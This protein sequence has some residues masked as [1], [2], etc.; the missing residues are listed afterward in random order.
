MVMRAAPQRRGVRPTSTAA[1]AASS[2]SYKTAPAAKYDPITGKAI[3][4]G[5]AYA[6]VDGLAFESL[7]TQTMYY[8]LLEKGFE[9][10]WEGGKPKLRS[11]EPKVIWELRDPKHPE[12]RF[13]KMSK[14]KPVEKMFGDFRPGKYT[15]EVWIEGAA[16]KKKS[17]P[18]LK[19]TSS[20]SAS[21]EV[22]VATFTG[23]EVTART[24]DLS[25]S[26]PRQVV[27][28]EISEDITP[29]RCMLKFHGHTSFK[30]VY[31]G[32]KLTIIPPS[33][34]QVSYNAAI[35]KTKKLLQ[36]GEFVVVLKKGANGVGMTLGWDKQ[37]YGVV[38]K[39]VIPNGAAARTKLIR[40]GNLIRGVQGERVDGKSFKR[41]ISRLRN[42]PRTVV[43][44]LE[45]RPENYQPPPKALRTKRVS[46]DWGA[47]QRDSRRVSG[48][49]AV[50]RQRPKSIREHPELP[51][52]SR[53]VSGRVAV[54]H[55]RPTSIRE[56]SRPQSTQR[57]PPPEIPPARRSLNDASPNRHFSRELPRHRLSNGAPP[58]RRVSRELPSPRSSAQRSPPPALPPARRAPTLDR[59]E[60][61]HRSATQQIPPPTL[62]TAQH[63]DLGL[64]T[65]NLQNSR[66]PKRAATPSAHVV[67]RL[68]ARASS[69]S[70]NI[71]SAV[72]SS[73]SSD[74]LPVSPS[75]AA[76]ARFKSKGSSAGSTSPSAI[77]VA[78]G[79]PPAAR[80][81]AANNPLLAG[82]TGFKKNTLQ[83]QDD[84]PAATP[85]ATGNPLLSAITGFKKDRLKTQ[86]S[87]G[88]SRA[89][90]APSSGNP[91]LAAI[92]GFNKG[93]LKKAEVAPRPAASA[94]ANPLLSAIQGFN[95]TR[96]RSATDAPRPQSEADRRA[97]AEKGK[98][99][100]QNAFA[101][102]IEARRGFLAAES[103]D[104]DDS[105]NDWD[106]DDDFAM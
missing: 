43:L 72:A 77:P 22:I 81:A 28:F 12:K 2:S 98:G 37:R 47:K 11:T 21:A 91:L 102:A 103:D 86:P 101:S 105:D 61:Y 88:R 85:V 67:A 14:K 84:P 9:V 1:S 39:E 87:P 19:S 40:S 35:Q 89:A 36:P 33:A 18:T 46:G 41:V 56:H 65:Q 104:D 8:E 6:E 49:V 96:M 55:Q 62:P 82:I 3:E 15:L 23:V 71:A 90:T 42:V 79:P 27:L 83:H 29:A 59:S 99:G 38:V 54:P 75:A 30:K 92:S 93:G 10:A 24:V 94:P 16:G 76:V 45:Q 52:H 25:S 95:K 57:S 97:V 106:D 66:S 17:H 50:P 63:P 100:I 31:L 58:K 53:R 20:R 34:A 7:Q 13:C 69:R 80:A 44:I 4:K 70:G 68:K 5:R 64:Q 78:A 60:Q 73:P 48:R 26:Y 51:T 74:C 32:A